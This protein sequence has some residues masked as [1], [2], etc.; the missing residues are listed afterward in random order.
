M[1]DEELTPEEDMMPEE[2]LTSEASEEQAPDA[3]PAE[4]NGFAE[5]VEFTE[6]DLLFPEL[7]GRNFLLYAVSVL[8][9]RALPDVRDGLLPVQRR[10][11]FAMNDMRLRSNGKLSKCAKVVGETMGNFHP[12]GDLAIYGALVRMAQDFSFRVPLINPQGNFGSIDGDGAGAMRYTECRLSV[13]AEE[14]LGTKVRI[15]DREIN[16]LDPA[17]LPDDFGRNY[18]ESRLEAGVLPTS[19]P[20]LL[21]NGNKGIAVGMTHSSP[22]HNPA[23]ILDLAIWRIAHPDA[24][25]KQVVAKLSGPDFPTGALVVQNEA[26]REAYLTGK[27]KITV[28]GEAHVEPLPGNR[29]KIV[30]TSLPFTVSKGS[31]GKGTGFLEVINRQ[32]QDNKWP[33]FADMTDLST[34]DMRIELELKRGS[35]ARAVLARLYKETDLRY[36]F[37][38]Q[39]NVLVGGR[40]QTLNLVQVLDHWLAFR[41]EVL[42]KAAEKRLAEIEVRLHKLDALIKAIDA[43]DAVVKAIRS[44]K[45][46]QEAKPKLRKLLK[47]DEQ[48]ASWIV[49]MPLGNITSLETHDLKDEQKQLSLE[50]KEL[51]TFIKTPKLVT[52]KIADDLRDLKKVLHSP[53]RT[54]LIAADGGEGPALTEFS[55]PAEDCLLLVSRSGQAACGQGTLQRGASLQVAAQDKMVLVAD[56]RT[57]QDWIVFTASGKA[58]RLRLAELPLI[59]RRDKGM[60]LSEIIGFEQN[61]SVVAVFPLDRERKGTVLFVYESGL[62]KR[63]E[64][65]DYAKV[66]PSGLVAANPR[67]GDH[68]QGVHDCPE[69]SDI[70]LVGAHGKAIRFSVKALRPMGRVAAGVRGM[71]LPADTLLVGSAVCTDSDQLLVLTSTRFAKRI[72]LKDIPQQGRDGGGVSILGSTWKA[73]SKYGIPAHV[74]LATDKSTLWLQREGK[75]QAYPAAKT[76]KAGRA[77]MPKLF[78]PAEKTQA[79]IVRED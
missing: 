11:L 57:D 25:D 27:G 46:R 21:I 39:M 74:A 36:T 41:K 58:F 7:L 42:V 72:P 22:P 5:Y 56:A 3:E 76:T 23:E 30:V 10:I 9:D 1:S 79:V 18:D 70:V 69:T 33:E 4:E 54:K 62:L 43:I 68:V 48:Q 66:V 78:E 16:A 38:M 53:R 13:A 49:E 20:N 65:S 14:V 2:D 6:G 44:S 60:H 15:G 47:I 64:W 31:G 32:Y 71:K 51:R 37:S 52:D 45:N 75:L 73:T 61:D 35:N 50:A 40:P 63:T 55:V 59:S 34:E 77:I 17:V 19:F 28:V 29:E 8:T 24:P 67:S 12:H 26:L